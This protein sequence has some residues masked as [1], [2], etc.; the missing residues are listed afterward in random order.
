MFVVEHMLERRS[1][2]DERNAKSHDA[3][4]ATWIGVSPGIYKDQANVFFV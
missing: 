1:Q 2:D 3:L 4:H